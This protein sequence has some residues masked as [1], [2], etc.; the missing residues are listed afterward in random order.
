LI[1][2]QLGVIMAT[3]TTTVPTPAEIAKHYSAAMDSVNLI[4]KLM[5]LPTR[6]AEEIA[7]VKRNVAHL[8]IMLAKTFWS[9]ENLAPLTAASNV[10]V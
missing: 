7:T 10:A 5:A 8:K 4:N 1:N 2:Y 6:S 9:T 3:P